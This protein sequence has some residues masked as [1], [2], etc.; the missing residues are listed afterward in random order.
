MNIDSSRILS[1]GEGS[2]E[3]DPCQYCLHSMSSLQDLEYTNSQISLHDYNI[4][5]AHQG[6]S[7]HIRNGQVFEH[8]VNKQRVVKYLV[9]RHLISSS[10]MM[11]TGYFRVQE[12]DCFLLKGGGVGI[13]IKVKEDKT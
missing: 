9:K 2:G 3:G 11:I 8:C 6:N 4:L 5:L 10:E 12:E 7:F 13:K 1:T